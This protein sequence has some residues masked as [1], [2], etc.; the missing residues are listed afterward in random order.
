MLRVVMCLVVE[1]EN[2]CREMCDR[3]DEV[4]STHD[5]MNLAHRILLVPSPTRL[6]P[7]QPCWRHDACHHFESVGCK[8][9]HLSARL[10]QVAPSGRLCSHAQSTPSGLLP[11]GLPVHPSIHTHH[12]TLHRLSSSSYALQVLLW[13][14]PDTTAAPLCI[15]TQHRLNIFGVQFLP[16]SNDSKIVTAAFDRTVQ[17]HTLDRAPLAYPAHRRTAAT[18]G[19]DRIRPIDCHTVVYS[20]HSECVK[21][22]HLL[23]RC[24][25]FLVAY[26]CEGAVLSTA[27]PFI[28]YN[29]TTLE[30]IKVCDVSV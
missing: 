3:C 27:T 25:I 24:H 14:Y 10:P 17:L 2:L 16:C 7:C 21:V 13:K 23:F 9:Y 4:E 1:Y 15:N 29:P 28:L 11:S 19:N 22:C 8:V 20:N 6:H 26:S 30:C 5:S 12:G 18:R